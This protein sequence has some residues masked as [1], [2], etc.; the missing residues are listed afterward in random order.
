MR[1]SLLGLAVSVSL[2]PAQ[3]QLQVIYTGKLLGYPRSPEIQQLRKAGFSLLFQDDAQNLGTARVQPADCTQDQAGNR[4]VQLYRS[5]P[6]GALN[7]FADAFRKQLESVRDPATNQI[8]VGT[9]DNFGVEL[10]ARLAQLEGKGYVPKDELSWFYPKGAGGLMAI[11]TEGLE[12]NT[13]AAFLEDQIS[14]KSEI[15]FDNVAAFFADMHYAALVPGKHDFYFGPERLRQIGRLLAKRNTALLGANLLIRSSYA[16]PPVPKPD[17]LRNPKYVTAIANMRWDLPLTPLPWMRTVGIRN[18]WDANGQP[19]FKGNASL[20][21]AQPDRDALPTQPVRACQNLV[22]EKSNATDGIVRLGG[23]D[24]LCLHRQPLPS[25]RTYAICVDQVADPQ[26]QRPVCQPFDVAT[27]MLQYPEMADQQYAGGQQKNPRQRSALGDRIANPTPPPATPIPLWHITKDGVIIFGVVAPGLESGIGMLNLRWW[28]EQPGIETFVATSDPAEAL[29][30]M[31]AYCQEQDVCKEDSTLL[32]LAQMPR[33]AAQVLN[34]RLRNR[35]ALV[36]AE[37]DSELATE[38]AKVTYDPGHRPVVVVPAGL[39]KSGSIQFGLQQATLTRQ[40]SR[41]FQVV[42]SGLPADSLNIVP[43]EDPD[44]PCLRKDLLAATTELTNKSDAERFRWL[45][46]HRMREF[47]RA[48]IALLQD[49]DFFQPA[50]SLKGCRTRPNQ[51]HERIATIEHILW[52]GDFVISR[53]ITG[54]SLLAVLR[55]SERLQRLEGDIYNLEAEKGRWLQTYGLKKEGSSWFVNGKPVEAGAS[56]TIAMSDYLAFGDTGYPD[57]KD[58]SIAPPPRLRTLRTTPRIAELVAESFGGPKRSLEPEV[59]YDHTNHRPFPTLPPASRLDQL[60]A[61]FRIALKGK[62]NQTDVIDRLG[63]SR[64]YWRFFIDKG[65]IGGSRY[66]HNLGPNPATKF[67]DSPEAALGSQNKFNLAF[68]LQAEL[69]REARTT[70]W[71]LRNEVDLTRESIQ[72]AEGYALNYPQNRLTVEAGLRRAFTTFRQTPRLGVLLSANFQAQPQTPQRYYRIGLACTD[73][74]CP[75]RP[76]NSGPRDAVTFRSDIGRNTR[77]H[78]KFGIRGEGTVSWIEAGVF[79][80]GAVRPVRFTPQ[81]EGRDLALRTP[82]RPG[83]QPGPCSFA[84]FGPAGASAGYTTLSECLAGN[85]RFNLSNE[86]ALRLAQSPDRLAELGYARG[87]V[88]DGGLF[89]NFNW[90]LRLPAGF[91]FSEIA[92][93][94]RGQYFLDANGKTFIDPLFSESLRVG[95][96]LPLTRSLNLKPTYTVFFYRNRVG[97][98]LL[99]SGSMDLKIEYRFDRGSGLGWRDALRY[100]RPR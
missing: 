45:T 87:T 88:L 17:I 93:E 65:E 52:K 8:L 22:I 4:C 33:D 61:Q 24:G 15:D 21:Y 39:V 7:P 59:Y 26:D 62:P 11:H 70:Q 78:G 37:A 75:P 51:N 97:N 29:T 43:F 10:M 79:L 91:L 55:E 74:P 83:A 82:A 38:R 90:R 67:G 41:S 44:N 53:P 95:P 35:F 96:T 6:Q 20:R 100:G 56:Y 63:Q 71:F 28:N 57:L 23:R 3:S 27:P 85:F 84:D 13:L 66:R 73:G 46:L 54:A 86:E 12:K 14:G 2:L 49:R 99:R 40:S 9:G 89:L 19:R 42:T 80:G 94:N 30:Q 76:D 18:A 50:A 58:S 98:T 5:Q 72:N 31:L 48:D 68:S 64:T 81:F 60:V 34:A 36:V 16:N 77:Y 92:I 69:R 32:L 47:A 1:W 25:E